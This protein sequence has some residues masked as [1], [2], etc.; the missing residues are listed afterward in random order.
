M[1]YLVSLQNKEATHNAQEARNLFASA[2][3]FLIYS[4][5]SWQEQAIDVSVLLTYT[6][7]FR[8][9]KPTL[10]PESIACGGEESQ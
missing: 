4:I 7:C 1:Q 9:Q 3:S 10:K 2:K 5:C 6:K 8:I